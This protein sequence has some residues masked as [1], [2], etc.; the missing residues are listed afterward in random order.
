MARDHALALGL[1][2]GTAVLR[3]YRWDRATVSFGRNE[4]AGAY[5][6]RLAP[7]APRDDEL[8]DV[9][10]V[11]R[12]TGGRAVL[13]DGELTYAVA[14]P[15]RAFGGLR[16]AYRRVN[17]GLVRALRSLGVAAELAEGGAASGP[18]AGPCFQRA[19]PGE[20]TVA[21]RKLVGS[22]QARLGAAFLQHGSLLIQ[23][24]QERL[25]PVWPPLSEPGAGPVSLVE[26]LGAAPPCERLV[27]ALRAGMA[28]VLGGQWSAPGGDAQHL[29]DSRLEDE[30]AERYR[31]W[32]WTWRR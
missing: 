16:A 8:H 21:G 28:E 7:L 19:A 32:W 6:Q 17:Q 2:D 18:H 4:P 22:A 1:P 25:G 12:P 26:L 29:G 14:A 9:A 30:L 20:V 15:L 23:A 3:L 31:S 10:F 13:H 27:N 11:R 5:R 24:G